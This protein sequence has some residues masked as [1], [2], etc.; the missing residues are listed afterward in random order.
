[1]NAGPGAPS[2]RKSTV[3]VV[4]GGAG[5]AADAYKYYKRSAGRCWERRRG[6]EVL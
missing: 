4:P 5:S 6:L 3:N 1:M 2:T